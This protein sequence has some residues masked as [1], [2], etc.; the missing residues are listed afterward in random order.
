MNEI[1]RNRKIKLLI[2]ILKEIQNVCKKQRFRK[3][4][5]GTTILN[6]LKKIT[7]QEKVIFQG[8]LVKLSLSICWNTIPFSLIR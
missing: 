3:C 5:T 2:C 1:F 8:L 4:D 6:T 7:G